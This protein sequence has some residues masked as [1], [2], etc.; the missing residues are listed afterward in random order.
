MACELD[1]VAAEEARKALKAT[2]EII[3]HKVVLKFSYSLHA[4][5]ACSLIIS[6]LYSKICTASSPAITG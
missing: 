4:L 1:T 3:F 2:Q 6:N 5:H